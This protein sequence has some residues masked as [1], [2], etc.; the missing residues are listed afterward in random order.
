LILRPKSRESCAISTGN[1]PARKWGLS[2]KFHE[3]KRMNL[4]AK[5]YHQWIGL[6][7]NLQEIPILMGKTMVSWR[8]SLKPIH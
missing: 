6:R 4:P 5:A 2:E 3:L 7:E 1:S 8:C